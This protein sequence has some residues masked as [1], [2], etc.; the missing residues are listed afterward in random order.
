MILGGLDL[1]SGLS[2]DMM[3]GALV[4]AGAPLEAIAAALAPLGIPH[5]EIRARRVRKMSLAATKVD[6]L[7]DGRMEPHSDEHS[8]C[9]HH[10]HGDHARHHSHHHQ[11]HGSPLIANV[12]GLEPGEERHHHGRHYRDIRRQIESGS[13]DPL[14]RQ[15]AL[16]VFERLAEAEGRVHGIEP[17]EVHFHEVGAAD[18]LADIVGACAGLR[19]LGIEKLYC[20]PVPLGRG[21]MIRSAHGWLPAPA[22][23]TLELLK[24]RPTRSSPVESETVTP[25]GAALIAALCDP[26]APEEEMVIERTGYGAGAKDFDEWD[27]PNVARFWVARTL[28]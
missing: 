3:L 13:L 5:L 28:G 21:G 1:V 15:R 6:V 19:L 27:V 23:A 18:A 2:G 17:E 14:D 4:D 24:G 26:G 11:S 10:H 16:A 8:G 7:V 12:R 25:T 22:P 9:H 20:G